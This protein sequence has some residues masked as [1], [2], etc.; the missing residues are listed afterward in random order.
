MNT[1]VAKP[2]RRQAR[3]ARFRAELRES[4]AMAMSALAAHKL[5]SAL[6][7]LGVT[8]GVFSIIVVMTAMRVLQSN[9][10][11]E[12]N[13]LGTHTFSVQKFPPIFIS[14]PEGW[15]RIARRK[16]ITWAHV[17]ALREK[18]SLAQNIAVEAYFWR[19]SI[20][21]RFAQME[22]DVPMLGVSAESFAAKNW[23]VEH[24]RAIMSADIDS[25]RTVCVLG[26]TVATQLFPHSSALGEKVKYR[27]INYSVIGV[28]ESRGKSLGGDQDTFLAIPI[29]TGLN[30]FGAHYRSLS[31]LVQAESARMLNNTMEQVRGVLRAI[32]KVPPQ[33]EDDFEVFTN[34][35][36][37]EQFRSMTFAVRIGAAVISSIALLAAGIGIMNIMLVSVTERTREIGIRR[38]VAAKKR[39]ILTQFI[40]E[41]IIICQVGGLIG[42][43]LGIAG[44]NAA[45][46]FF[47]VPPV[48]P[49]DWAALA[50]LICTAVG[51][52]FGTYPAIKA[53]N[54]DPVESLRYE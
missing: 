5:R 24:G 14:G 13:Q 46:F 28:L 44:G 52:V 11:R 2:V 16:N 18:A 53:A 15:E 50:M 25:T 31:I 32:R 27:G 30:R 19:D 38:A 39:N 1:V 12:M 10:E 17:Q 40:S 29:T 41:A 6:T 21:S 34:D 20:S 47:K 3:G 48:F 8:V 22:V 37:I 7:L 51:L 36:L 35:S 45:A 42:A 43:I 9:I 49:F 23:I 26:S 54:M 4:F 33:D